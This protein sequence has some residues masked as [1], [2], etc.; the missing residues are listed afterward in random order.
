MDVSFKGNLADGTPICIEDWC[1][2]WPSLTSPFC[3]AVFP[4]ATTESAALPYT[5]R[6]RPVRMEFVF[7]TEQEAFDCKDALI[8]GERFAYDYISNLSDDRYAIFL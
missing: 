5:K 1:K 7:Q 4:I 3:V 2:D 6:G 8:S